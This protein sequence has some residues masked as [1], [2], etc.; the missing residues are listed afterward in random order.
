MVRFF[1]PVD[2]E[3]SFNAHCAAFPFRFHFWHTPCNV[4]C[5]LAAAITE[6]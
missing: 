2:H 1:S 6:F 3:W 5:V 4:S